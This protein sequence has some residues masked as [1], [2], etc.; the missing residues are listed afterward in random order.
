[1]NKKRLALDFQVAIL[2]LLFGGL[3]I[4]FSDMLLAAAISDSVMLTR[5]QT[6]KG[7][8]FVTASALVIFLLLRRELK[9]RGIAE[10]QAREG[11]EYFRLLFEE[12]R[13]V[14]FLIEPRTGKIR[15]AN[16]AAEKFYGYSLEGLRRMSLADLVETF[17]G[18]KHQD[19]SVIY[20]RTTGGETRIVDVY[21]TPIAVSGE[22]LLFS[23][24]HDMTERRQMEM[25]LQKS[26][27][28]LRLFVEH[29]PA[30]IAMFDRDMRYIAASRRYIEEYRLDSQNLIGRSHYEVFP[31]LPDRWK[32]VHKRCLA[33]AVESAEAD[34]FLRANGKL[35]WLRWEIHP[36]YETSEQI[37]GIVLFSEVITARR[38]ADEELRRNRDRLAELSRKLLEAQEAERRALGRELHDQFGQILTALKLTLETAAVL[39]LHAAQ[40]KLN[41]AL[42]LTNDLLARTSRLSL[43]L[44]PPMLDDFGLVPALLWHVN[45]FQEQSGIQVV[46]NHHEVQ[47]RRFAPQIETAAYR[48]IQEALTNAAR[49]AGAT[50]VWLEV[51]AGSGELTIEIEDDGKGFDPHQALAKRRGLSSM[52]ERVQLAGGTFQIESRAGDGARVFI[53]L[54]LEEAQP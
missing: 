21:T 34:P 5:L 48:T 38:E 22:T 30:A 31:D 45:R 18:E 10:E 29:A 39:P 3:W 26:E 20:H 41:Q 25:A 47:G 50:T 28:L 33:G 32:E 14:M 43:D 9:L 1:M 27:R 54:P 7:W 17:P 40:A 8:A 53:R 46:F 36:W 15:N 6:Y 42:E 24:I 51:R 13:D 37:G 23:I 11:E 2:Y 12:N 16:R 4:L 19:P 44:R 35:E 52:R 49:H